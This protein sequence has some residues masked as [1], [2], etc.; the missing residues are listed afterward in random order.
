MR[1]VRIDLTFQKQISSIF[2]SKVIR[3][4]NYYT[5]CLR[6]ST[7]QFLLTPIRESKQNMYELRSTI[8]TMKSLHYYAKVQIFTYI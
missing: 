8:L 6:I 4:Y 1:I 2:Q 7:V 3:N 5:K